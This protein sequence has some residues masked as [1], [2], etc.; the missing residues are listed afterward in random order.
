MFRVVHFNAVSVMFLPVTEA[1]FLRAMGTLFERLPKEGQDGRF[2]R[3][4]AS[5]KGLIRPSLS[6][7]P[8][9]GRAASARAG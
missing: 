3:P 9:A 2:A 1:W 4:A 7:R 8:S 6:M 5:P